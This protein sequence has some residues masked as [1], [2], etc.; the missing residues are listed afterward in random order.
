MGRA[1]RRGRVWVFG[2]MALSLACE[3]TVYWT[4]SVRA[5]AARARLQELVPVA[6]LKTSLAEL[7]PVPSQYLLSLS[8]STETPT[9]ERPEAFVFGSL[10]LPVRLPVQPAAL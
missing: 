6:V 7:K 9:L 10:A 3:R 4:L 8:R 2:L 1:T 5:A